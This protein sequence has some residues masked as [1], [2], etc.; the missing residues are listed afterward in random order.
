MKIRKAL[1]SRVKITKKGKILR[2]PTQQRHFKAKHSSKIRRQK[3][4]FKEISKADMKLIKRYL[5]F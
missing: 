5:K 3:K 2:R 1:I 4:G